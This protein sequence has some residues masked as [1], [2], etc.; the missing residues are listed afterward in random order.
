[1]KY[2]TAYFADVFYRAKIEDGGEAV[3]TKKILVVMA[4]S[5][6]EAVESTDAAMCAD[7]DVAA[8]TDAEI[9]RVERF[10]AYGITPAALKRKSDPPAKLTSRRP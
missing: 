3:A 4:D 1:M 10:G 7:P 6:F 5:F 9:L 2:T 8:G